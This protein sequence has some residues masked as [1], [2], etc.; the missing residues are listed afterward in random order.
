MHRISIQLVA[1]GHLWCALLGCSSDPNAT[2]PSGPPAPASTLVVAPMVGSP[3]YVDGLGPRDFVLVK[4]PVITHVEHE[5]GYFDLT[6]EGYVNP[7]APTNW[8]EAVPY[9]DGQF[10]MRVEVVGLPKKDA[11]LY[12]TI[13]WTQGAVPT[14]NGFI[15]PAI[16]ADKGE[17]TY[18]ERWP[19]KDTEHSLDGSY[20]SGV[21]N[22][23]TWD[24][25]FHQIGG[26]MWCDKAKPAECFPAK[27]QVTLIV[28]AP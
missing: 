16:Y 6:R 14:Q 27:V 24:N 22:N 25:A 21:G 1:A 15:R 8:L 5:N 9:A 19:V 18:S 3:F 28:R 4:T 11:S 20:G 2:A 23:W 17:G 7:A 10:E 12:Y 26:D 13:T